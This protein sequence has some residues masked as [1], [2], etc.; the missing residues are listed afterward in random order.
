MGKLLHSRMPRVQRVQSENS[1]N[2]I[3]EAKVVTK[4]VPC[5]VIFLNV[6][7]FNIAK[8][9]TAHAEMY[10]LLLSLSKIKQEIRIA[11]DCNIFRSGLPHRPLLST[12]GA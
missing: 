10:P 7:R 4:E 3:D 5:P 2:A 8:A 12:G 11:P 6:N 9:D 1:R